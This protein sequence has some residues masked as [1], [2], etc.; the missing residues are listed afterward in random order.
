MFAKCFQLFF[1]ILSKRKR[2][3]EKTAR[4]RES[5]RKIKTNKTEREREREIHPHISVRRQFDSKKSLL[6][7]KIAS[8]QHRS[9]SQPMNLC[10]NQQEFQRTPKNQASSL[11]N[12]LIFSC[13]RLHHRPQ[14]LCFQLLGLA[15][16]IMWNWTPAEKKRKMLQVKFG[17]IRRIPGC[18]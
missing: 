16:V 18:I 2:T 3:K 7:N 4:T 13:G 11:S 17:D 12:T 6:S 14:C 8:R 5:E 15:K 1:G 9:S 10:K